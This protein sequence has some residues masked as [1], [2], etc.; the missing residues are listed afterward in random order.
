LKRGPLPLEA[1]AARSFAMPWLQSNIR[2]P[3]EGQFAVQRLSSRVDLKPGG[4][5]VVKRYVSVGGRI[6][7]APGFCPAPAVRKIIGVRSARTLLGQDV[8]GGYFG[9]EALPSRAP[10][11][12]FCR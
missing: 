11:K 6:A 1:L 4:W 5:E 12:S 9:A 2:R 3:V 10:S 7:I 8:Y